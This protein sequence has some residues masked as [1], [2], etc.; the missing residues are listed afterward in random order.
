MRLVGVAGHGGELGQAQITPSRRQR[1]EPLEAEDSVER[2]RPVAERVHATPKELP[3]AQTEPVGELANGRAGA[4]ELRH[5]GLDSAV[6]R[7][8]QPRRD[9]VLQ[10]CRGACNGRALAQPRLDP[11][12]LGDAP[13]LAHADTGVGEVDA[14]Q[15]EYVRRGSGP[16]A[17]ADEGSLREGV[18]GVSTSVGAPDEQPAPA[19]DEL[20]RRVR[21]EGVVP[22]RAVR[23]HAGDVAT[24][25]R[26]RR[27]LDPK[28][29]PHRGF[30]ASTLEARLSHVPVH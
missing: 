15:A 25:R 9:D 21:Q 7:R 4:I 30:H 5:D 27:A 23:P 3:L 28:K 12:H 6:G 26:P 22:V 18:D 10:E 24:E 2:L 20:H 16:E 13:K 19:P 11:L 14:V 29:V 1:A 8:A 17:N